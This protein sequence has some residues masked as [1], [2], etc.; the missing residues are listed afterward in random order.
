MHTN[1]IGSITEAVVLAALVKLRK[2]IV[3][4]YGN[5]G[6]YDLLID[7]EGKFVKVQCK[8]GILKDGVVLFNAYTQNA[9]GDRSYGN[10]VDMYGVFCPQNG[11]VYLIPAPDCSQG[12]VSLRITPPKNN[13]KKRIRYAAQYEI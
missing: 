3:I 1:Q 13:W 12:K 5:F 4:P 8:T 7:E 11:K 9:G 10:S 2:H 6:D